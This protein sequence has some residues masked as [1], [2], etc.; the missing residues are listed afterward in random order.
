[1]ANPIA[2]FGLYDAFVQIIGFRTRFDERLGQVQD[3]TEKLLDISLRLCRQEESWGE[4]TDDDMLESR[5]KHGWCNF[6]KDKLQDK[7]QVF[8]S[9]FSEIEAYSYIYIP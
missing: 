3:G 8:F 6:K 4:Y 9:S 1:M 5:N 7:E 2:K